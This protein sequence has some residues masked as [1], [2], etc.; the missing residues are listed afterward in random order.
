MSSFPAGMSPVE[1]LRH[2]SFRIRD[3]LL[4]NLLSEF[5]GTFLLVLIGCSSIAQF[6]L[7]EAKLNNHLQ[8]CLAWGFAIFLAVTVTYKTSVSLAICSLG[9]LPFIHYPFY[10]LA[11]TFGGFLGAALCLHV[12]VDSFDKFDGGIRSVDGKNGTGAV[13]S[14]IDQVVGTGLLLL[15]V[16]AI[17]DQRNKIPGYLHPLCFG[18]TV[19]L[20]TSSFGMNLGTPINPAR[21]FG[22]RLFMLF[23]GY[24]LEAFSWR[25]YYFGFQ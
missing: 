8:V 23:G 16:C 10:V 2:S 7:S 1:S 15:F 22:P 18:L 19:F 21:D 4:V 3:R 25:N 9:K 14:F 6:I 17:I 5:L 20:L 24:G 13:F 12:Y 11:Q